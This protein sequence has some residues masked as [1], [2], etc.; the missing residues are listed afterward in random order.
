MPRGKKLIVPHRRRRDLKTDYHNR[1]RLLKSGKPRI[2]IRKSVRNIICQIVEYEATGDKTLFTA[3][4]KELA[5]F[6]WKA[7]TGNIPAAYLTGLL[8]GSR[9]GKKVKEAVLDM[10]L[11][12]STKGN[13]LYAALKGVLDAGISVP[14]S[15]EI[16]PDAERIKGQHVA[17]YAEHLKKESAEAYKKMFSG[18]AKAKIAPEELPKHFDEVKAKI[19]KS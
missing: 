11:Y 7:G 19:V 13:R 8:C 1:L 9:A 15:E 10:G 16:L 2:V 6:G 18:Y 5:K 4:S 17:S 3:D 12:R 14:H